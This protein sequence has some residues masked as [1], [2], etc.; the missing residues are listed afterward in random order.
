MER[1]LDN[2]VRGVL[3]D[4]CGYLT[5]L[6]AP[7]TMGGSVEC[8]PVPA[9]IEDFC[10]KRGVACVPPAFGWEKRCAGALYNPRRGVV[11]S[12]SARAH[13]EEITRRTANAAGVFWALTELIQSC[14]HTSASA[15]EIV[16]DAENG[17]P[18]AGDLPYW[19]AMIMLNIDVVIHALEVEDNVEHERGMILSAWN[20]ND[21]LPADTSGAGNG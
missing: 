4:F 17:P 11:D 16:Q 18:S 7:V 2:I 14:G 9:L 20:R 15:G 19:M 13:G 3:Y 1:I 21:H 5:S 12:L 6:S 8:T 10:L